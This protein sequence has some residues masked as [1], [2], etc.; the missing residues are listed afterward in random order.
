[1]PSK[2]KIEST[3]DFAARADAADPLKGIKSQFNLPEG[4][5]GKPLLYFAGHSLGAQLKV[6][7]SDVQSVLKDWAALG[8]SGY[9]SG[10]RPWVRY[11]DTL[12]EQMAQLVGAHRAEIAVMNT[13][14]VNL[15]LMLISFYRP[16]AKRYK[17]LIEEHAFPSDQYAVASHV[18]LH[19]L[20]HDAA[21]VVARA[22]KGEDVV[23]RDDLLR[24]IEQHGDELALILIG[25]VN[26]YTGQAFD[27]RS[28]TEAG[29]RIGCTV[30]FDLAHAAG[31]LTLSLHDL[32]AD[33]AVWCTYK[34]L[35]GGPASPGV[36]FVHE[37]HA[38]NSTLPR[39]A[40][41]W[42]H[43]TRTRFRM[44]DEFDPIEGAQGWQ[45][46][47]APVLSTAPLF[48]SLKLFLEAGMENVRAK[49]ILMTGYLEA[50]LIDRC[51]DRL[52]II[53]PAEPEQRGAQLSIRVLSDARGVYERLSSAG[54]VADW[55]EPDAIRIAP[56]P[57]YTS[58]GDILILAERIQNAI[59]G[60][61]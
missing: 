5:D 21:V 61:G 55:R 13:L 2:L 52:E 19:G 45:L 37:R 20:D 57:L 16:D 1:M 11:T 27:L 36:V 41:W 33:F 10:E 17:I 3:D 49:S 9:F 8:V 48:G 58:F 54:V 12:N 43:N 44:P 50:L 7:E 28:I 30:G 39:L 29:H 4:R 40:G 25:G 59:G 53:T 31:N 60:P 24:L 47:N 23:R 38:T 22:R 15:N 14:S 18:A 26:Y 32:G 34:Y 46:S 56:A 51:A 35:N 42:G 6:A